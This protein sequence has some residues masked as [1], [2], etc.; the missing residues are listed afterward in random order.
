LGIGKLFHIKELTELEKLAYVGL[1][2]T[3]L[4]DLNNSDDSFLVPHSLFG[5]QK[6]EKS[7]EKL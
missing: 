5:F 2:R 1:T 6:I 4:K 7:L 3:P